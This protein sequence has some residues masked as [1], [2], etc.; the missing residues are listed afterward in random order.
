MNKQSQNNSDTKWMGAGLFAAFTASLCCI[1]PVIVFAAGI[2]GAA[3][4]FSWLE[5][6]RPYL[7]GLTVLLLG[8]A[9]YQKLK[10]QWDPECACEEN[11]SFWQTKSF[12]GIV[13]VLAGLLLAFPY[14]SDAFFPK[15]EQ[16]I[17]YVQE[18]QVQ[19]ITLDIEGMTCTG[20]EASVENAAGGVDGVLEAEASYD[21]GKATV[22]Y[23]Q[24]KTDR[25]TIVAAINK[26]GFTVADN[27]PN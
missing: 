14:Y 9:W 17:V 16:K 2:S 8:F 6:F 21:T 22:K 4:A 1:T 23:D 24:S 27:Q 7:I 26:T 11:P 10:P 19:T 20:C 18:S 5:P 13:T 12:L 15:Q 25:E 3:S